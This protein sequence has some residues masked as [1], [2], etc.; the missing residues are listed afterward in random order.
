[1]LGSIGIPHGNYS[2]R[3]EK[4]LV[5]D[6]ELIAK[7][8]DG[9]PFMSPDQGNKV[10][11]HI[12]EWAPKEILELGSAHGVSAAYMAAAL[13]QNGAG[14]VTTVDFAE[15]AYTPSPPDLLREVG[16]LDWVTVVHDYST[17]NWFLK[18]KIEERSD[19]NGNCEPLY[20]FVYLDGSKNW[21]IDGLAVFLIEK[22][23]KPNGWLLMDDLDWSFA[24]SGRDRPQVDGITRR[25][26]SQGEIDEAHLAKVFEL[27]VKQHPSF[28]DF[29]LQDES[30]GWA[31]KAPGLDRRLTIEYSRSASSLVALSM[32]RAGRALKKE[33]KRRS[34][35]P[36]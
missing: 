12:R 5:V 35:E 9:I 17:Y 31:R 3:V 14:H 22:L 19:K 6:L 36:V 33:L 28:S 21:T 30:W 18:C 20:D 34:K 32:V 2:K 25:S 26:L 1:M 4:G 24:R 7:K 10:Y 27:I 15:A 8:L 29:R 23:L 16:L 13:E 11:K